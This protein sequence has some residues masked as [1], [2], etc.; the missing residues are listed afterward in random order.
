LTSTHRLG[1]HL[2]SSQQ[3]R[4]TPLY[5]VWHAWI[6]RGITNSYLVVA[7]SYS[8]S[9]LDAN[10]QNA[11]PLLAQLFMF[12]WFQSCQDSMVAPCY[13]PDT[14][15]RHCYLLPSTSIL[16][17]IHCVLQSLPHKFDF[18]SKHMHTGLRLSLIPVCLTSLPYQK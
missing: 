5:V 16:V 3:G 4:A 7:P 11:H 18:E 1:F 14:P 17:L 8:F 15:D 10:N 13:R 6:T 9:Y 12:I 2:V